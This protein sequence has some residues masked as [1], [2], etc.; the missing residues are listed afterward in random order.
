MTMSVNVRRVIGS[1]CFL[2][3]AVFA[4]LFTLVAVSKITAL[5]PVVMFALVLY[6][7]AAVTFFVAGRALFRQR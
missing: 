6:G 3:A 5:S 1:A 2:F 7:G 4:A